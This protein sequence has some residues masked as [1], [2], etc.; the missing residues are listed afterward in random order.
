MDKHSAGEFSDSVTL[1]NDN[2]N[3]GPVPNNLNRAFG[4]NK[5]MHRVPVSIMMYYDESMD[6]RNGALGSSLFLVTVGFIGVSL[7]HLLSNWRLWGYEPN[8]CVGHLWTN[9]LDITTRQREHHKIL[10]VI[11]P[12]FQETTA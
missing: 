3:T 10:S 8:L 9:T 5:M 1:S 12:E 11:I 2:L 4:D 7:R 6:D